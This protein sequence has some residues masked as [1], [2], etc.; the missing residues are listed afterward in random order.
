MIGNENDAALALSEYGN[1]VFGDS[2]FLFSTD[3]SSRI[4][5]LINGVIYKVNIDNYDANREEYE[6]AAIMRDRLPANV[7]IPELTLYRINGQS[8]LAAEKVTGISS[9]ECWDNFLG[10]ECTC[11][12]GECLDPILIEELNALGWD[13]PCYGNA[14]IDN[15]IVYL[16][17]VA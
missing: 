2:E 8:V 12:P 15:G 6:K 17:D 14:I 4:V 1:T 16:V 13:D 11:L 9:G 3:G 10:M 5:Y 7:R